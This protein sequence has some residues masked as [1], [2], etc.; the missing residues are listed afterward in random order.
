MLACKSLKLIRINKR[1]EK[2]ALL[3]KYFAYVFVVDSFQETAQH[4]N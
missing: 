2:I 4:L 1:E 3:L